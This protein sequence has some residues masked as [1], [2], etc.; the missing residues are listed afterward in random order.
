MLPLYNGNNAPDSYRPEFNSGLW[1]DKFCNQ[2]S[3]KIKKW[4]L[5]LNGE[6]KKDWINQLSEKKV[7]SLTC[8]EEMIVRL[9]CLMN[10][11]KGEARCLAT[12]WRFVTGLG[13]E[14]PVENG[15][16][17]H[18]GLGVPYLP[19]SSIKGILRAWA[20]EWTDL[21]QH[22]VWRIFGPDNWANEKSV[23]SILFFDALPVEPI[24][25][26]AD[27]MTPHYT[28]Y[29][30]PKGVSQPPGDWFEPKPIPF[31]TV[32]SG[33]PFFFYLAPRRQNCREDMQD[34]MLVLQWLEEALA[35][36]GAGAKT[37]AGY[38]RF[39]R[40]R[41]LEG[42]WSARWLKAEAG[43]KIDEIRYD[44]TG[45]RVFP[46]S[47][48]PVPESISILRA[49]MEQD[50]YSSNPE[51]FMHALTTRWLAKMQ[52]EQTE[53][54]DRRE[55]AQLLASWYQRFK[56]DMWEKPNKKNITKIQAIKK[57]IDL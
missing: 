11:L 17:W 56:P 22:K 25:V 40:R 20:E 33:Q 14:H 9:G 21:N 54:N 51:K 53:I 6:G 55:I 2:W 47:A 28:P 34:C 12:D 4:S 41:D 45:E 18:H 32:A 26:Q 1:Y 39:T 46:K 36:I 52:S 8:L 30:L 35:G 19:G 50:G 15:F 44:G 7:G 49:S 29:Y 48:P 13:R 57:I 10:A 31:L 16:A 24:K 5:G 3:P 42:K 37:A 27:V 23:G 38:G 43:V